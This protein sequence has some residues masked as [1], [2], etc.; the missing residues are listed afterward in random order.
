MKRPLVTLVLI[1]AAAAPA[2]AGRPHPHPVRERAQLDAATSRIERA[3]I[4]LT[5]AT[6]RARRPW[7]RHR[8]DVAIHATR[9]FA[10]EARFFRAFVERRR[11]GG[12]PFLQRYER[13]LYAYED[14]MQALVEARRTRAVRATRRIVRDEMAVLQNLVERR[15]V[16]R[17]GAPYAPRYDR[18]DDDRYDRDDDRYDR[19]RVGPPRHYPRG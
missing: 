1:A 10:R 16:R 8:Q 15:F 18:Y 12:R 6:E 14:V 11:P 13:L 5:V 7:N 17:H 3:A 19:R 2:L 4:D 9:E